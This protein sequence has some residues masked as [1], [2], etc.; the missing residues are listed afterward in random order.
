MQNQFP[1]K[2]AD[3]GLV[4]LATIAGAHGLK[5]ALKLN[6]ETDSD[7]LLK[8]G[9]QVA[10]RLP[11]GENQ[12]HTIKIIKPFGPKAKLLYFDQIKSRTAAQPLKGALIQVPRG[13]L[14]PLDDGTYYWYDLIGLEVIDVCRGYV[15]TVKAILPTGANDVYVVRDGKRETLIPV[16]KSVVKEV[17]LDK[18]CITVDLP[19][20]L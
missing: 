10:L 16:I 3:R 19:D 2:K 9:Q 20:G 5:G 18:G 4:T 6:I 12:N 13:E 8:P 14:P 11:S 15:G 17:D 7:S 1:K